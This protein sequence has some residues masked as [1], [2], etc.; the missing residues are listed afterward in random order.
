LARDADWS[1]P[2]GAAAQ[3]PA[4]DDAAARRFFESTFVPLRAGDNGNPAGLFTGYYEPELAGSRSREGRFP[5]PLLKR[6]ADLVTVDLGEFRPNWRGERTAGRVEKG[7]LVPYA[8]RA[9]IEK[10]ALAGRSLELAW[11]DPVELFFLQIQGS[12]RVVLADGSVLRVGFD[13]QNGHSYVPIGRLLAERGAI[14][15][16]EVTMQ[17]IRAWLREHPGEAPALLAQ[18]PSYVF[19]K[20]LRGEGPNG[21]Q[22]VTLTP[23][24]SLAVDRSFIPLGAPVYLAAAEA[25]VDGSRIERLL[26]AQDIGGAIRGPV[27]GD[28]FW[29]HGPEAERIAGMMKAKGAYYLLLPPSLAA[30]AGAP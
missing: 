17:S 18:N 30:R 24:R 3:V 26:V 21:A 27:R 5:A 15:R 8:G 20:E 4:G 9:E 14:P 11:A 7:R 16:E 25:P 23:G 6:P 29:G 10:G 2:C 1:P 28:V 22:G 19:F 13:G 12:G